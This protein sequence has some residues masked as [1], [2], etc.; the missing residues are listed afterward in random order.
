[1]RWPGSPIG[2]ASLLALGLVCAARLLLMPQPAQENRIRAG[3]SQ[4]AWHVHNGRGVSD[5]FPPEP[6]WSFAMGASSEVA[7]VLVSSV[8]YACKGSP[9]WSQ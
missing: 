3:T 9:H 1:M 6:E 4:M 7:T 2:R 5:E 8:W